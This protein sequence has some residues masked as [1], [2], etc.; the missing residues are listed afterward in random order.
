MYDI[1][2]YKFECTCYACPTQFEFEDEKGTKYY[3]RYRNGYWKL[4]DVTDDEN[5]KIIVD[6]Q[7]GDWL[8]GLMNEEEFIKIL[9][10]NGYNIDVITRKA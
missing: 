7:Y 6:G 1:K 4:V 2:A 5:W 3:F 10:D 9:K 8:D